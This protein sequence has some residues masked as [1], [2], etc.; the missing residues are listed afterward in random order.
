MNALKILL[1]L[2]GAYTLGSVS[3]AVLTSKLLRLKDPR[4][5][6]SGNPGATNVLRSGNK[7]AAAL[8]LAGDCLKGA[9]AVWGARWLGAPPDVAV[10]AG[11]AAFVGHL[12][13]VF[14]RFKGGKGV[15]TA[16]GVLIGADWRL[17]CSCGLIWLVVAFVTRY[18]SA[19]AITAGVFCPLLAWFFWGAHSGV[20]ALTLMALLL[21]WRHTANIKRL[22]AG[23]ESRI[24]A[25]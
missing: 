5:Y 22:A 2:A 19:A 9:L 14:L 6:G 7:G 20:I 23:T 4:D 25:K 8:T 3:F 10:W 16:L 12:F 24:G 15:A 1:L 11:F 13:P 18:S 17:A 21:L